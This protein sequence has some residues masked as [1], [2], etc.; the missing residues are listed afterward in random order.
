MGCTLFQSSK[1]TKIMPV[2]WQISCIIQKNNY[3]FVILMSSTK[4]NFSHYNSFIL[5]I[6]K[7]VFFLLLWYF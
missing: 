1:Q 7:N 6:D 4:I 3:I 2:T 5:F